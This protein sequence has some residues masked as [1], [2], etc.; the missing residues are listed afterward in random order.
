MSKLRIREVFSYKRPY[1][2]NPEIIDGFR[3]HFSV[4]NYEG[5]NLILLES[6]INPIAEVKTSE[7]KRRPAILIRSSPHKTGSETTP[8]QD[9]FDVDNGHIRYYGDNKK[10]GADPA[11]APGNKVLLKAFETYNNI[12]Q[13]HLSVPII[14]YKAV[15]RNKKSKGFVEFNGFGI[16]KGVELVTQYDRKQD[17]TFSNFAFNFHVFSIANENEEFDWNWINDRRNKDLSLEQTMNSA[18][19]SWKEWIKKGNS[20]LEKTRRRVSKLFTVTKNEQIPIE[21]SKEEKILK[22][23]YNYYNNRK[24]RFEGLALA[25][26]AKILSDTVGKYHEGW[27]TPSTSDGGADFYG[28]LEVGEGFGKVKLIVLGQAKCEKINTPTGGTHIARTVARLKRGWIGIYVTTSYF[29][30]AVQREVIED[31]YPI[32]LI[33]GL[34]LAT[35]IMKILHDDGFSDTKKYLDEVDNRYDKLVQIRRPDELLFE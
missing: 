8:W 16:I 22:E 12:D 26:A 19:K 7:G 30:E 14:F 35:T 13:R 17:R 1:K 21:G 6:G 18:P 28:R 32:M 34:K 20:V 4:T 10:P 31:E 3:N 25:V 5:A 24:S 2:S 33:N 27:I 29:S 11:L 9:I 23:I 15:A